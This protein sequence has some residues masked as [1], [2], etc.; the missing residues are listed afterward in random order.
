MKKSADPLVFKKLEKAYYEM[1][2]TELAFEYYCLK[3]RDLEQTE[4]DAGEKSEYRDRIEKLIG[5]CFND[6][7]DLKEIGDNATVLREEIKERDGRLV[8]KLDRM[9]LDRYL[10][11]REG[12]EDEAFDYPDNDEAARVVLRNIFNVN[13][14]IHSKKENLRKNTQTVEFLDNILNNKK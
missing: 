7:D 6:Y 9:D 13:E 1:A 5:E 10:S 14:I 11:E 2:F 12:S 8:K 4:S 3:E